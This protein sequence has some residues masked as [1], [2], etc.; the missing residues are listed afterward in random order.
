MK[1]LAV[2]LPVSRPDFH[3]AIRWL[4]WAH[5]L[6]GL[7]NPNYPDYE[8]CVF[9]AR[10]LSDVQHERLDELAKKFGNGVYHRNPEDYERPEYG[11]AAAA[12]HML[13]HALTLAEKLYPGQPVIWCEAD[14]VPMR[15]SWLNEIQVEYYLAGKPFLGDFH[16]QTDIPHMTGNAVYPPNWRELAPSLLQVVAKDPEWGWDSKCSHE[17]V[18][19]MHKS[20]TIQQI[21]MPPW[22]NDRTINMVHPETALFHRDKRGSLIDHLSTKLGLSIPLE[23]PEPEA[24]ITILPTKSQKTEPRV[25][26][27]IVTHAKD[28]E[29][30]RYCVRGIQRFSGGFGG[31][32]IAVPATERGSY[33][34]LPSYF[35]ICYYE[36]VPGKGMLKHL[37]MKCR[38]DEICPDADMILHL[39]ADCMP[40]EDFFPNDYKPWN[41][42]LLVREKYAQLLNP[43]RRNWQRTVIAATGIDCA[44][45]TMVRHPQI[46]LRDVYR[47]TRERVQ[48]HTGR[49]FDDYV[50]SGQNHFPQEFCEFNALGAIALTEF[51][52]HYT[53]TDYDRRADAADC[54]QDVNGQWQYI[55]RNGRDKIIETWSHGGVAGYSKLLED[56]MRGNRP[57]FFV[58]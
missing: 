40:W 16:A 52:S 39:D 57:A 50:L 31:V 8:L 22:F 49:E 7:R 38:A 37:V 11:Y 33:S 29:F 58:K 3:L 4:K 28:M 10:S 20:A 9:G 15:P 45:E 30:L 18:P 34:W 47:R 44:Y 6:H 17:T 43:N 14:T 55:Y 23:S 25:D 27:L 51:S 46:H 19:Q 5:A 36:D 13:L 54:G 48:S 35:R 56:I 12:N 53:I 1:N 26:I 2:I 42:P 32:T 24:K 41:K 21:W